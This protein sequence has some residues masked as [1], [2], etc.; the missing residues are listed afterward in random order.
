MIV[1]EFRLLGDLV[2]CEVAPTRP[3][4]RERRARG[5]TRPKKAKPVLLVGGATELVSRNFAVVFEDSASPRSTRVDMD[6]PQAQ[7]AVNVQRSGHPCKPGQMRSPGWR[8]RC[9]SEPLKESWRPRRSRPCEHEPQPRAKDVVL[10]GILRVW[11]SE[12]TSRRPP[13]RP[14]VLVLHSPASWPTASPGQEGC[15]RNLRL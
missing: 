1:G 10:D 9:D 5:A 15:P 4:R 8:C 13:V 2:R 11:A 6:A 14:L 3:S 12:A 7:R